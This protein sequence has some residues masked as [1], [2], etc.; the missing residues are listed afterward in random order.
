MSIVIRKVNVLNSYYFTIEENEE[1]VMIS[2]LFP[3]KEECYQNI[4]VMKTQIPHLAEVTT[5]IAV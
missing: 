1:E 3:T 5:I 4:E 2:R